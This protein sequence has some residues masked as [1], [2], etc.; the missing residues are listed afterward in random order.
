MAKILIIDDEQSIRETLDMYFA[1]KGAQVY[2]AG[3]GEKG[4]ALY[5]ENKPDI[6]ILD[7]RLPD[8][9]GLEL[10]ARIRSEGDLTKVIMITAYHDME[11]TIEAM[12]QGAFD[13]IHKPLDA[14]VVDEVVSR[15]LSILDAERETPFL[16]ETPKTPHADVII[17][18]SDKMRNI[19][20]TIGLL[21]QN[22]AT[23][24]IQGETGT[25]KELIARSIHRNSFYGKEPFVTLDCASVVESLMESELFGHS[26]GAFTGASHTKK[27]KIELAGSGTL[28]LDEIG[29]LPYAIQGKLLGFL[30]RHEYMRVGGQQV[31]QARCRVIAATNR[32]L[33]EMVGKGTF[34]KDLFYRLRV[35][36]ISAPPLRERMEDMHELV[37]YFLQKINLELG[38]QV[39]KLQ[40]GVM[41][42]LMTHPWTGNVRE[43]EN[44]LTGA[45]VKTRGSVLLLD[46]IEDILRMS[47]SDMPPEGIASSL[48]KME[49]EHIQKTL[50][51]LGWRRTEAARRLKISLPTPSK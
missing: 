34:R 51:E 28:F 21:C 23:V 8:V 35:V 19:F 2:S 25:G 20:K 4:V 45:L 30:Q 18:S 16:S 29:E 22:R 42:R 31:L 46:D 7:I 33:F 43:L 41:E 48:P 17:G 11:S 9:N 15:A 12:K 32:D 10:L 50:D 26:E 13:Y 27:G 3:T 6:V 24:L 5:F 40:E 47:A 14:D 39:T 49:K 36:T 38:A 44:L 37:E 1:E